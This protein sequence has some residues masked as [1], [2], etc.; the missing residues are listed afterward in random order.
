MNPLD[1]WLE[2]HA[3]HLLACFGE[4]VTAKSL[5]ETVTF[6]GRDLPTAYVDFLREH[7]GQRFV[8]GDIPGAGTLAPIFGAFEILPVS[9]AR[10]EWRSMREWGE[11]MGGIEAVGPVRAVYA[12]EAWWPFTVIYGSSHHHCI[13]LD[14]AP[15]G[16]VG[17]VIVVS[18]KDDRRTVIAPS[19]DAFLERLAGVLDDSVIE[20][21]AH[22]IELLDDAL[23]WLMGA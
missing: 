3:P 17:Q 15:G 6:L 23:D 22:G 18:M 10:G 1:G 12:H 7:D 20:I 13:D 11:G 21:G 4:P 19:L 5:E 16:D 2:A 14:P 8:T 9:Y